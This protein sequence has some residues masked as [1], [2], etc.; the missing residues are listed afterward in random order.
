MANVLWI[1]G[2]T[3]VPTWAG[4]LYW[5]VVLDAYIRCLIGWAM[6]TTQK[7]QLVIPL[8]ECFA[9]NCRAVDAVN[10]AIAQRKP[11]KGTSKHQSKPVTPSEGQ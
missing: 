5:A 8:I 4:F 10:M 6:G 9:I 11:L 3:Y 7:A 1:A 2:I